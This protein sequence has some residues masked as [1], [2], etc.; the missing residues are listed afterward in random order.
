MT[1]TP[2]KIIERNFKKRCVFNENKKT[3]MKAEMFKDIK[4]LRKN[5]D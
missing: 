5:N 3:C 2:Q 1:K 4:E